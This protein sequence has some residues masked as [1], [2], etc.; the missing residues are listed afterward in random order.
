M[1]DFNQSPSGQA[2]L[3]LAL[4]ELLLGLGENNPSVLAFRQNISQSVSAGAT[5]TALMSA[6]QMTLGS[7]NT[8]LTISGFRFFIPGTPN[9][10]LQS[11]TQTQPI[12]PPSGQIY[13]RGLS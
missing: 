13:P 8:T 10:L 9:I 5:L 11:Q 6:P 4:P 1:A 7:S 12:L 2:T 3:V